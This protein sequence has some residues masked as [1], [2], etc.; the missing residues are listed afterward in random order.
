MDTEQAGIGSITHDVNVPD[1]E[2]LVST[3][4]TV[5]PLEQVVKN[6]NDWT[7]EA[8]WKLVKGWV[9]NTVP[10]DY[11]EKISILR[12]D[13]DVY[14]PTI[15]VLR[16]LYDN[17]STGGFIIIDDWA[18]AGVRTAVMEFWTERGL[19]PEIKAVPNSTPIYWIKS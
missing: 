15:F 16:E 8:N 4:I 18:L 9:Q 5:H 7:G 6:L 17:I 11:P 14:A 13:M 3:G 19:K 10:F 2:L 1:E 12:L